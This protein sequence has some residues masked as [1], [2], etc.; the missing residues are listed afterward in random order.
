MIVE[1]SLPADDWVAHYLF[2]FGTEVEILSPPEL[3]QE[4]EAYAKKIYEH[5]KT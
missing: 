2:S 1:T 4:L 5:Y 3:K